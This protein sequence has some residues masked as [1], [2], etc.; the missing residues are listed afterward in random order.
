MFAVRYSLRGGKMYLNSIKKDAKCYFCGEPATM[1]IT[2]DKTDPETGNVSE[3]D[4]CDE[5]FEKHIANPEME[6]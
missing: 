5:C 2:D 6:H 3:I 4:I 1:T